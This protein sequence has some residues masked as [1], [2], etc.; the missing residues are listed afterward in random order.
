MFELADR[1]VGIYKTDNTTKTVTINP[2]HFVLPTPTGAAKAPGQQ[3]AQ[4]APQGAEAEAD[5]GG[6]ENAGRAGSAP[7]GKGAS[8]AGLREAA[9]AKVVGVV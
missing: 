2:G 9:G 1:L 7:V 5:D 4:E 3:G 6:K 8:Q